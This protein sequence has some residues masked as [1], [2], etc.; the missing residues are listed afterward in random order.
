MACPQKLYMRGRL[1][2]NVRGFDMCHCIIV[3]LSLCIDH[4]TFLL[5]AEV[6]QTATFVTEGSQ[7]LS[8]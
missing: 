7:T 1:H 6:W 3:A 5:F 2:F 8:E 4:F